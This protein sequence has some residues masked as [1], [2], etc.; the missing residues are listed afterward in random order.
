MKASPRLHPNTSAAVLEALETIFGKGIYADKVLERLLRSNPKWGARD[1][2][3][4]AETTYDMVR[5]WRTLWALYGKEP[6]LKRRELWTLFGIYL[7]HRGLVLPDWDKLDEARNLA[8]QSIEN[9]GIPFTESYPNWL[10][11]RAQ[12]ELAEK[13]PEMAHELNQLAPVVLR[14]N[15]LNTTREKLQL[16]LAEEGFNTLPFDQNNVGLILEERANTFRSKAFQNGWFEVQDG[17]SQLIAPFVQV[18]PGMRV[19]DACAGAGGKSLH[20]AALMENKGHLLA[21]D[22]EAWK[23]NELKKRAK[24]NGV[25]NLETRPIEGSKTIKRLHESADRILLDVPCSGTGVIKRNPD[26]KWKLTEDHLEGVIKTQ[27]EILENYSKMLKPGG[28]LVYATCSIFKSENED[29]VARF[30]SN[31]PEFTFEEDH[32]IWPSNSGTDGFYMA[33]LKRNA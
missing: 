15:T 30:L 22:V 19:I 17:G 32:R 13:W 3:F 7:R 28:M 16:A 25:H 23:L 6:V 5:W 12:E 26:T 10:D 9:L 2:G 31:H 29:Q 27:A 18:E 20:L 4:V 8:L 1:R 24:R 11:E 33:R 21:M 14:T